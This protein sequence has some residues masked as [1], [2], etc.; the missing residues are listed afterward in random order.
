MQ[1]VNTEDRDEF[2]RAE[3][4]YDSEEASSISDRPEFPSLKILEAV[5]G[6]YTDPGMNRD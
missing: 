6:N 2:R 3:F 4:S 1:R 5:A